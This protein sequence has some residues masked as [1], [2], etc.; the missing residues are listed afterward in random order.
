MSTELEAM[1]LNA[2]RLDAE[3]D[4][5]APE[6]VLA[7]EGEA[8]A[9]QLAASGAEQVEMILQIAVPVLSKLFPSLVDI[10][11]PEACGAIGQSVAPVLAKYGIDLAAWG[12]AWKEEIM[13]V[14]VCGPIVMATVQGIKA[15]TAAKEAKSPKGV[16]LKAPPVETKIDHAA[17]A[18]QVSLG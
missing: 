17:V 9:Q 14:M 15:D 18:A 10:Y 11:T 8:Q 13:M 1:A 5:Q 16:T 7:Q 4:A 12:G 3:G 6:A 2:E